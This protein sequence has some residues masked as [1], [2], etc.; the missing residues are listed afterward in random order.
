M[1]I[2]NEFDSCIT[3]KLKNLLS[4]N[5]GLTPKTERRVFQTEGNLS[6]SFSNIGTSLI[7]FQQKLLGFRSGFYTFMT[8]NLLWQCCTL[9]LCMLTWKCGCWLEAHMC[10]RP[11]SRKCPGECAVTSPAPAPAG[12]WS[13]RSC[14]CSRCACASRS[15]ARTRCAC[16]T[17]PPAAAAP[18]CAGRFPSVSLQVCPAK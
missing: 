11:G 10:R 6:G 16:D 18:A 7:T 15:P 14:S 13:R 3:V 17:S 5:M 2:K 8:S 9:I 12:W 4:W 1:D